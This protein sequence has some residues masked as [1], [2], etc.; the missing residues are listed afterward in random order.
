MKEGEPRSE[1]ELTTE[2]NKKELL[3]EK[4]NEKETK[5]KEAEQ[6]LEKFR[7]IERG[8]EDT[9]VVLNVFNIETV[10]SC[11]GHY[12]HGR[13][14]P[15]VSIELWE[16]KPQEK[17]AGQKEFEQEVYEK[18]GVTEINKIYSDYLKEFDERRAEILGPG[19]AE[20]DSE[21]INRQIARMNG[22]LE[23]EY[24]ITPEIT[25]KWMTAGMRAEKEVEEAGRDGRLQETNEYKKWKTE[26]DTMKNKTQQFLDEFYKNRRAVE[27]TKIF[28]DQDGMGSWCLHNGGEDYYDVTRRKDEIPNTDKKHYQKILDGKN[29][30]KEQRELEERVK[31]YRAE[32]QE[33]SKFLKEKYF[34]SH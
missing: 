9:V 1:E 10:N 28:I 14:A 34:T 32:F 22:E 7:G 21:E 3:V 11:E 25:K 24:G 16:N 8:I 19:K 4:Q 12:N 23:K 17:Y 30:K 18:C 33:F 20:P 5:W 2:E 6:S 13:V 26:N 31:N 15:W 27:S 29:S